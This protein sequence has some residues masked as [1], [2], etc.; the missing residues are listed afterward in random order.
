MT[1][2]ERR[3]C[4]GIPVWRGADY[5]GET[6]ES[7]LDQRGVG[8]R[9]VVSVDGGDAVSAI[10][11]RPFLGD[12]RV[13]LTVQSRR[14]GWVR[15]SST[16]LSAA[17]AENGD[18]VCLQPQD[19][20]MEAD[21][22][23]TLAAELDANE[24]AAVVYCDIQSFGSRDEILRQ[25]TVTGSPVERQMEL[26]RRHFAAIS[27]RGLMRV[28][29]VRSLLPMTGNTCGDF[30]VDTVWMARQALLGDLIRV[31]QTLYRKRYHVG[32]TYTQWAAW[33][34]ERRLAAWFTHC[35]DMFIVA[36]KAARTPA[37]RR[38]LHDAA[39]SRF[40]HQGVMMGQPAPAREDIGWR[41][42]LALA[43]F[44]P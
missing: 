27:Y 25:P 13:S 10:A 40:L 1:L 29:A 5:V 8:V 22:L 38:R 17:S 34:I 14:L 26:M 23:A 12:P 2:P 4:V 44:S 31:P 35:L 15:N 36:S 24:R 32:N 33:P 21:Y 20:V 42:D 9:V 7:V 11:C 16:V 37:D 6:L 30:A 3:V 41:F 39:R 18:Y 43:T 19:D 28:A